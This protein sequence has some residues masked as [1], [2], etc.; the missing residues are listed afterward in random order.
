MSA[1]EKIFDEI[2]IP[3]GGVPAEYVHAVW[4]KAKKVLKRVVKPKTGYDLPSVYRELICSTMQLW[5]IGDFQA[6]VVTQIKVLPLHNVL[7]I[8]FIAGTDMDEWR[9]DWQKV[10]EAYARYNNCEAVEFAGRRGWERIAKGYK[11]YKPVFTIFRREL[12]DG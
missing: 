2:S 7:W 6:V 4:P 1:A 3:I 12:N 11:D 8:M 5:V 10:Q 9:D